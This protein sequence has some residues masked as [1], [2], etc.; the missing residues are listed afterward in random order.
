MDQVIK[1]FIENILKKQVIS[2]NKINGKMYIKIKLNNK[3]I[4]YTYE[5]KLII[6]DM[7]YLLM[8]QVVKKLMNNILKKIEI[9]MNII[10]RKCVLRNMYLPMIKSWLLKLMNIFFFIYEIKSSL[11]SIVQEYT[12]SHHILMKHS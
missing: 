11:H 9:L 3:I 2:F 4:V 12:I 1:K 8:D 10:K 7:V 6:G 5:K